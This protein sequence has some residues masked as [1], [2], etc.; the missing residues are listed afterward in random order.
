MTDLQFEQ[1]K[2]IKDFSTADAA[3]AVYNYLVHKLSKSKSKR[4]DADPLLKRIVKSLNI[5]S[6]CYDNLVQKCKNTGFYTYSLKSMYEMDIFI[7]CNMQDVKS[8]I[9]TGIA[10][11]FKLDEIIGFVESNFEFN[12]RN[13]IIG[14]LGEL[15]II[16][17]YKE[18]DWQMFKDLE[19]KHP[20]LTKRACELVESLTYTGLYA[21]N[22]FNYKLAKASVF[23][24]DAN[25]DT[26]DSYFVDLLPKLNNNR[27]SQKYDLILKAWLANRENG[28]ITK[29]DFTLINTLNKIEP[30]LFSE[31]NNNPYINVIKNTVLNYGLHTLAQISDE[32]SE[33]IKRYEWAAPYYLSSGLD[34]T[35][36]KDQMFILESNAKTGVNSNVSPELLTASFYNLLKSSPRYVSSTMYNWL[37]DAEESQMKITPITMPVIALAIYNVET[38]LANFDNALKRLDKKVPGITRKAYRAKLIKTHFPNIETVTKLDSIYDL[39]NM[40]QMLVSSQGL[41]DLKSESLLDLDL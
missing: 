31:G 18:I 14:I 2:K 37:P 19:F 40:I 33:R 5:P 9:K 35:V 30:E 23:L 3:E 41:K 4:D 34:P 28:L 22:N 13:D 27:K 20:I 39:P 12:D 17:D 29:D 8:V 38:G 11:G 6:Y 36:Q 7:D 15:D 21:Y 16:S 32:L 24:K 10:L 26:L 1:L 25:Q